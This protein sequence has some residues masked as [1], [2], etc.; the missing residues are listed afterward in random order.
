MKNKV[1]L[2]VLYWCVLI[3]ILLPFISLFQGDL[4]LLSNGKVVLESLWVS[5]KTTLVT[6]FVV[7][8][9]GTPTAYGCARLK[10]K[11]KEIL[12]LILTLPLILP[13]AVAGLLLLM[14]FGKKG[15]IG[16]YLSLFQIQIPF[17]MV[18]VVMAQL[19]VAL[20]MYI[21][22]VKE[23]FLKVNPKLERTAMTLGDSGF[24]VF[25]RVTLPLAKSSILTAGI[26][27]WARALAEFGATIMFAG[28]LPG[29]TQTLP[30]AIYSA[31]ETDMDV[32]LSLARL[33]VIGS[34]SMLLFIY[35]IRKQD[36]SHV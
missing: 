4:L 31:M 2:S 18:A 26:M 7:I 33:M 5:I 11:G 1:L 25:F 29:K 14:T 3:C 22:T 32:A 6:M 30:L 10:F 13:P 19:F 16:G 17:T 12:D 8:L 34:I 20:P 28:N 35:W 15:W 36:K 27:A 23:G 9:I 24:K 21:N